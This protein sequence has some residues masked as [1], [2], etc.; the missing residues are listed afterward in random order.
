MMGLQ[1]M[2]VEMTKRRHHL[3]SVM[4]AVSYLH[5]WNVGIEVDPK[6]RHLLIEYWMSFLRWQKYSYGLMLKW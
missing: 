1:K 4:V 5:G 3:Q 6:L 2:V